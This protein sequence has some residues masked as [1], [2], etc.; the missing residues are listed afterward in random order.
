MGP[1]NP[2]GFYRGLPLEKIV[3][4]QES[5]GKQLVV[6]KWRGMAF[7]E[8]VEI[9]EVRKKMPY[10]LIDFL[11]ERLVWTDQ[12]EG[13]GET[14]QSQPSTTNNDCSSQ[15]PNQ[16]RT[17]ARKGFDRGLVPKRIIGATE[18]GHQLFYLMEWIGPNEPDL[19]RAEDAKIYAPQIVLNFLLSKIEFRN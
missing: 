9:K 6:I 18:Q 7:T 8:G 12:P 1:R 13:P 14:E 4:I 10:K 15:S 11:T 17:N 5:G 2:R 19:V 3:G 16:P